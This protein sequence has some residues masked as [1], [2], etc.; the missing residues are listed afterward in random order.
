VIGGTPEVSNFYSEIHPL[1][2]WFWG[3]SVAKLTVDFEL[4]L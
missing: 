3:D 2:V 1:H 4:T